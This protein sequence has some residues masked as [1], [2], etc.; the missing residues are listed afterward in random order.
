MLVK[1][2]LDFVLCEKNC[3]QSS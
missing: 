2:I 3:H 1:Q